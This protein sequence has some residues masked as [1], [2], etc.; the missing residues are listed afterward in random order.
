MFEAIRDISILKRKFNDCLI[1]ENCSISE[2]QKFYICSDINIFI[3]EDL[4]YA[5]NFK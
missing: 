4:K 5:F 2:L 1:D 3:D